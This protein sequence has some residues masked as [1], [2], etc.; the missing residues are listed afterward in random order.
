M[1]AEVTSVMRTGANS[2]PS[3]PCPH[4]QEV[5][6]MEQPEKKKKKKVNVYHILHLQCTTETLDF[7]KC[8]AK[9]CVTILYSCYHIENNHQQ[10][11]L[12]SETG[13]PKAKMITACS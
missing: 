1:V 9:I 12:L 10:L 3:P 6:L 11:I 13:A 8:T 7:S 2:R 4:E 5:E